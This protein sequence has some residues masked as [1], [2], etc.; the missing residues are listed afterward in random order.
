MRVA[1]VEFTDVTFHMPYLHRELVTPPYMFRRYGPLVRLLQQRKQTILEHVALIAKYRDD[2]MRIVEV[3]TTLDEDSLEPR[4]DKGQYQHWDACALYSLVRHYKPKRII[5]V[6]SGASTKFMRRAIRDEGLSTQITSVDPAPREGID[7]ICDE[8]IRGNF[9]D[10]FEQ[11]P[12]LSPGDFFFYDGSHFIL[13]HSDLIVSALELIPTFPSGVFIHF[14]DTFI[15]DD[16]P[17]DAFWREQ[18][19]YVT[20]M[21]AAMALYGTAQLDLL[22]A[23]WALFV[24]PELSEEAAKIVHFD[25]EATGIGQGGGSF[26]FRKR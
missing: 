4:F 26:W 20:Y 1:H 22:L 21:V 9:E 7:E 12:E 8:V 3:Q 15:P 11:L 24:V 5:E 19:I 2:I 18:F 14:H 17:A 6:G 10:V 16:V 13:P 23:N 25:Q